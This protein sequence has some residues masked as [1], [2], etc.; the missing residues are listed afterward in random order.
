MSTLQTLDIYGLLVQNRLFARLHPGHGPPLL[1]HL[2]KLSVGQCAT[3]DGIIADLLLSRHMYKY[4]LHRVNITFA[5]EDLGLHPRDTAEFE[6]LEKYG[7][8]VRGAYSNRPCRSTKDFATVRRAYHRS[9]FSSD[10]IYCRY[11]RARHIDVDGRTLR[12]T[13]PRF[14]SPSNS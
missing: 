1:P 11:E 2:T 14:S 9:L 7:M 4:P 13:A 6:R 10:T 12:T 5:N 8:F 3:T